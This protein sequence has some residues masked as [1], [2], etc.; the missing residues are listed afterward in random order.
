[1]SNTTRDLL[2][3]PERVMILY[4][5]VNS[6]DPNTILDLMESKG[7][8][9]AGTDVEGIENSIFNWKYF[10][11]HGRRLYDFV[12]EEWNLN[13]VGRQLYQMCSDENEFQEIA[14]VGRSQ[15]TILEYVSPHHHECTRHQLN[16]YLGLEFSR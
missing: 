6:I 7:L 10:T 11:V 16:R 2:T 12:T 8:R 14:Y 4:W 3:G 5:T 9:S 15:R 1:M 13:D